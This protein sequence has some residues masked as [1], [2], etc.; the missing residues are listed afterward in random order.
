MPGG[1]LEDSNEG[2]RR[3]TINF[4]TEPARAQNLAQFL[5]RLQ[6]SDQV[7]RVD[8]LD[9]T[10]QAATSVVTA[11]VKVTRTVIG[12]ATTTLPAAVPA[13]AAEETPTEKPP[14]TTPP[15]T[16]PPTPTPAQETGNLVRNPSFESWDAESSTAAEWTADGCTLAQSQQ[17]VTEGQN[18]LRITA[19]KDGATFYQSHNLVA[20]STYEVALDMQAE[21]PATVTVADGDGEPLGA[22]QAAKAD[23]GV[24]KY[25]FTLTVP[26][27]PGDSVP[28]RAPFVVVTTKL[29]VVTVDN[30]TLVKKEGKP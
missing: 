1:T 24:Y 23:G 26:G 12:D 25:R 13:P 28:I 19:G 15:P 21:G 18:S 20:G 29:G 17:N 7:L 8:S 5:E 14:T 2:Y 9:I 10:R 22:G 11:M 6:Q 16:P 27:T 30:A 3:Y 4:H